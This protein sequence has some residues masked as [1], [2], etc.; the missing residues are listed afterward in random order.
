MN[1][2]LMKNVCYEYGALIGVIKSLGV[3]MFNGI[4]DIDKIFTPEE[5]LEIVRFSLDSENCKKALAS[6]KD[7]LK[8]ML[9]EEED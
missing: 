2:E 3:P 4:F 8:D 6:L 5:Q 7:E 9:K 1:E